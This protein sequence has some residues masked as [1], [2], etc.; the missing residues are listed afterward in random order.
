[1]T[2]PIGI[3]V[4]FL[5]SCCEK[6]NYIEQGGQTCGNRDYVNARYL[7]KKVGEKWFVDGKTGAVVADP[8]QFCC[9]YFD[10]NAPKSST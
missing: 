5:G 8:Q 7:G 9:N 3:R 4:P 2:S 1:M 6:C 10:W